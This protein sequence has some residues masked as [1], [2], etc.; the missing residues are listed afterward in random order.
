M[1]WR[2]FAIINWGLPDHLITPA[3]SSP[4]MTWFDWT[5]GAFVAERF[6]HKQPAF[7]NG[8]F[9]LMALFPILIATTLFKPLTSLSFLVASGISAILLDSALQIQW[10]STLLSKSLASI[11][12]LSYSLYLWHQP[13]L[14][15]A[16][17]RMENIMGSQL[18]AWI[19]IVPVLLF[20]AW[21]SFTL[22]EQTGIRV[23]N[24]LWSKARRKSS[25]TES[26]GGT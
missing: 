6:F 12:F 19:L 4:L 15:D 14:F 26:L 7:K 13:R 3:L 5:L 17:R 8:R 1:A 20:G 11:G 25:P 2:L 18:I 22:I 10:R 24:F 9:L 23:G 16:V 21:L